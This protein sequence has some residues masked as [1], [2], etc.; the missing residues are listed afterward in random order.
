M[1]ELSSSLLCSK[2]LPAPLTP[3][4]LCSGYVEPSFDLRAL[5][6]SRYFSLA[7]FPAL[8]TFSSYLRSLVLV[9]F[10]LLAKA[11]SLE[12]SFL[13]FSIPLFSVFL[14]P[15]LV[16]FH[17]NIVICDYF[18]SLPLFYISYL[19]ISFLGWD[20]LCLSHSFTHSTHHGAW[21]ISSTKRV[22]GLSWRFSGKESACQRRRCGFDL[23]VGKIPRRWKQKPTPVFLPGEFHGQRSLVGYSPWSHKSQTRISN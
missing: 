15:A 20:C 16:C 11:S 5:T 8:N 4:A 2:A 19:N 3:S 23:W 18:L 7:I 10:L 22:I 9:I 13:I 21:Y 6:F 14:I 12:K 17:H 1:T